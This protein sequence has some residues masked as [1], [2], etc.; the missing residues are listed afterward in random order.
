MK[1]L[2]RIIYTLLGL[3]LLS[4]VALIGVILYAEYSGKRFD[5]SDITVMADAQLTDS[6][7]RLVYD[8]NGNLAELPNGSAVDGADSAESGNPGIDTAESV[9]PGSDSGEAVNPGSDSGDTAGSNP[10]AEE[11]GDTLSTDTGSSQDD[12][13]RAYVM[14]KGSNLFHLASC[15]YVSNIAEENRSEMTTTSA[16]IMNAGYQP[17]SHCNP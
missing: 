14:D 17:C 8:E 16:K 10:P 11:M 5:P 13:E 1:I 12:V 6:D 2:K 9:N 15:D 4:A 3:L 7:S